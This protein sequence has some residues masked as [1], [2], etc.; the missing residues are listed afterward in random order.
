MI[1]SHCSFKKE[2]EGTWRTS[3]KCTPTQPFNTPSP[4]MH[5]QGLVPPNL[6]VHI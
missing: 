3:D 4:R 6:Y 1:T 5:A 2:R